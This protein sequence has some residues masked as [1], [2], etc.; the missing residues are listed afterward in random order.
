ML[1]PGEMFILALPPSLLHDG[2]SGQ[3]GGKKR[4]FNNNCRL[5]RQCCCCLQ[6]HA[7]FGISDMDRHTE[8]VFEE[9]LC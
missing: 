4:L 7:V 5:E 1:L 8:L 9:G 6:V 2:P 3:N